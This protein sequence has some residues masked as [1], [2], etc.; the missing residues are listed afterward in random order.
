MAK[1]IRAVWQVAHQRLTSEAPIPTG[2]RGLMTPVVAWCATSLV[3]LWIQNVAIR[4]RTGGITLF[5]LFPLP[6]P[7]AGRAAWDTGFYINIARF[8][9]H[10]PAGQTLTSRPESDLVAYFPGY[11][12]IIRAVATVPGIDEALAAVMISSAAG[13]VATVLFW[14][15]MTDL[16]V[17]LPTRRTA[18]ALFLLYPYAF[19]ITGVAYAEPV[20]LALVLAAF[21]LV[22]RDRYLLAGLAGAAATLC[23]PNALPLLVAL[24]VLAMERGEAVPFL[25]RVSSRFADPQAGTRGPAT[26][27]DTGIVRRR[28]D[29]ENPRQRLGILVTG[30]GVAGFSLWLMLRYGDPLAFWSVQRHYGQGSALDLGTWM[31]TDFIRSIPDMPVHPETV[32]RI[33]AVIAT[34]VSVASLRSIT[35]RL[36]LGYALFVAGLVASVLVGARDFSPGGRYLSL[37][38]PVILVLAWHLT[39]RP[40]LRLT[41]L[42]TF[43]VGWV[44]LIWRFARADMLGW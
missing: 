42:A 13:L 26:R 20:T 1:A 6:S 25:R 35:R 4:T 16:E 43:A 8:G 36:G 18:L 9:Y 30:A 34:G 44:L 23:R 5:T 24:P 14:Q 29:P 38:F 33:G 37:G 21:V 7:T 40:A 19:M 27:P 2:N 32:N 28:A 10:L 3:A 15:W 11:P 17:D 41:I 12:M 22:E 31:K 39:R